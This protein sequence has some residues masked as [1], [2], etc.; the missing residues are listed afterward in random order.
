MLIY[1]NVFILPDLGIPDDSSL[2]HVR[3]MIS[4]RHG[5]LC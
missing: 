3:L 1:A 2:H 4:K 5:N